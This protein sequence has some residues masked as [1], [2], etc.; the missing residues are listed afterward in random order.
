MRKAGRPKEISLADLHANLGSIIINVQSMRCQ[1]VVT[2]HGKP[3]AIIKP[4]SLR[5]M[6]K[7]K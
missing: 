5:D 6:L 7:G 4:I 2:R 1:I 3:V